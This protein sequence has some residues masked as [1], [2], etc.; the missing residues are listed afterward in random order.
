MSKSEI[1]I[2]PRQVTESRDTIRPVDALGRRIVLERL[3]GLCHGLLQVNDSTGTHT[4]GNRNDELTVSINV[5]NSRFYGA[6]A[7]GGAVGAAEAYIQGYWNCSDLTNAIRLLVRNREVLDA[8]DSGA[9]RVSAPLRKLVHYFNRNTKDGSRKNIAAHYDLG[10]EFFS[11][12][13]DDTMM[14]SSAIFEHPEMTLKEASEAKLN[15]ICRKLELSP[16]DHVLEIG[17]GWGGFAMYAAQ[18]FGCQITTTTISREQ[19]EF[20]KSRIMEAGL[21]DRVELLLTDY[22][23]LEGRYDKIVSIEMIEAV[24]HE[25]MATYFEKCA[26][27]LKD[28]G[29]MCLQ[30]I[31]IADQR[32]AAA[33]KSV[34]FI[35]RYIFPG[36]F[37]PSVT[38]MLDSLT[39]STD[40]RLIHLEDIGPHYAETLKRWREAFSQNLDRVWSLGFREEFVR[41]WHYYYCYCEGAFRE[42][43]IGDVQAVFVKPGARREPVLGCLDNSSFTCRE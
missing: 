34:D 21:D 37:L 41:M 2:P 36:G 17:T 38:A 20:A 18:N 28:D 27:L 1:A 4:F 24:G 16:D 30:T 31:T 14:Y 39:R 33:L 42:R 6:I 22:R 5:P 43:A 8:M 25:Y 9:A 10:N 11:L 35:Q 15:R 12:W 13:L 19:F 26:S 7:F 40:M 32:Y 23:E 3:Q 29:M